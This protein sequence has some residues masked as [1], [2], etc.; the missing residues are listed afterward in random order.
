MYADIDSLCMYALPRVLT[1]AHIANSVATPGSGRFFGSG[2][3]ENVTM[4]R[5][6]DNVSAISEWGISRKIGDKASLMGPYEYVC[7]GMPYMKLSFIVGI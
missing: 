5:S 1:C 2:R 6:A 3:Q 7:V 4:I